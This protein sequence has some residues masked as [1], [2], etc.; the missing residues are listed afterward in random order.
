MPSKTTGTAIA[1]IRVARQFCRKTN[2]M[3]KTSAM[4]STRVFTTSSID[5]LTKSVASL[6]MA[7]LT[8]AGKEGWSSLILALTRSAV[9]NA[10]APVA[11]VI[12]IPDAVWPFRRA[13]LP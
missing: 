1:G 9:F 5:S 7:Y 12:C 3:M 6:G 13:I 4:A 11:K 2:M 10:L 8:P